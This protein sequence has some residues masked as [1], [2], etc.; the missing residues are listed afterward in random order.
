MIL[1]SKLR[2]NILWL[3]SLPSFLAKDFFFVIDLLLCW[4]KTYKPY[5][6]WYGTIPLTCFSML[7]IYFLISFPLIAIFFFLDQ[8]NIPIIFI[9]KEMKLQYLNIELRDFD[10]HEWYAIMFEYFTRDLAWV[11]NDSWNPACQRLFKFQHMRLVWP[12]S[13]VGTRE[14]VMKSLFSQN[15][16]QTLTHKPYI[17]SHKST[18][19]WLNI[20]TIKFDT[21]VKQKKKKNLI[22]KRQ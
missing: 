2:P 18:G 6:S 11:A 20:I 7:A 21:K 8:S 19:K 5:C 16:H 13:R 1:H 12:V 4:V 10:F 17:K 15:L 22:S 3:A 14:L 9:N